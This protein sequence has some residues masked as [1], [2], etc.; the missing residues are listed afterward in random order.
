M[1][2]IKTLLALIPL[3]IKLVD[4]IRDTVKDG[5]SVKFLTE[6]EAGIDDIKNKKDPKKIQDLLRSL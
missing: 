5:D 1:I 2:Y 6:L 4:L 3:L